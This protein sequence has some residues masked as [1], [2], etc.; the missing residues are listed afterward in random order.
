MPSLSPDAL[1]ILLPLGILFSALL[2][3]GIGLVWARYRD[4][5]KER[6]DRE[7]LI[8]AILDQIEP[9]AGSR[10]SA[11][12]WYQTYP[13]S[14]L[15]GHTAQQLAAQGRAYEVIAFLDHI[16]QGGYA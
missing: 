14:A 11:W 10:P 5:H 4:H 13:I 12:A 3:F 16:D 9:W 6:Q 15:G 2:I 8:Q 1:A 7:E